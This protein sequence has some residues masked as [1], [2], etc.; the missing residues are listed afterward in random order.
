MAK[1]RE[2]QHAKHIEPHPVLGRCGAVIHPGE[3]AA[4]IELHPLLKSLRLLGLD[5]LDRMML[6]GWLPHF[7]PFSVDSTKATTAC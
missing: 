2:D 4:K 3:E 6:V 1:I 7:C 5:I